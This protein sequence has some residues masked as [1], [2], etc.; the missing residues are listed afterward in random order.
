[1]GVDGGILLWYVNYLCVLR[2]TS[3]TM[4]AN[5]QTT[6]SLQVIGQSLPP[7]VNMVNQYLFARL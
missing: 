7:S 4:V 3:L 1:M 6:P 5:D 2:L